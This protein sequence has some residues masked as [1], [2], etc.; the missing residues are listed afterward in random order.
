M[1]VS[2]WVA[3]VAIGIVSG[4]VNVLAGG[5]SFLTLPL[6]LF[7]GLPASIANGTNRVGVLAQNIGGV[8]GFHRHQVVEWRWAL[9]VSA[10]S[11]VGAALGAFAALD[12]S[13]F[14][15]RRILSVV[16]VVVTLWT[17]IQSQ[18]AGPPG[19]SPKRPPFHWTMLAGFFVV[20][21]YGGFIQAGVGFLILA[22]TTIAGMDLVRGN[23]VKVLTVMLLTVL[24]L[25]IFAGAG[26]VNW[27]LGLALGAGNLA[28]ATIGV[29]FAVLRGHR[30]LER[31]VLILVV[32]FAVLLWINE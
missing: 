20:G 32:V 29:R 27:P 31:I 18:R 1:T 2:G 26:H 23:A 8:W 19:G 12:I 16:M 3:C 10:V 30:W 25:A 6:L 13:D 28:G 21:L 7:L 17:L 24:S 15:F 4:F 14:A 9:S 22:M 11:I 5:G